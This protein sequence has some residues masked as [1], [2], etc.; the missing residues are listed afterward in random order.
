MNFAQPGSP[1]SPLFTECKIL[2]FYD[3]IKVTQCLFVHKTYNNCQPV[4]F[5]TW[6]HFSRNVHDHRTRNSQ[7]GLITLE[8]FNTS[9]YGRF[10]PLNSC[11]RSWNFVQGKHSPLN[12]LEMNYFSFRNCLKRFFSD[13]YIE[14]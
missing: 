9:F 7:L 12:L 3:Q 5:D 6:F 2:K 13:S 8:F 11:I 14:N 10:S 1:S 4:N